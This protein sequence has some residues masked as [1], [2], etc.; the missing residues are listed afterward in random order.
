[1]C[2]LFGWQ[3]RPD[4]KFAK[5]PDYTEILAQA[6]TSYNDRRGGDSWGVYSPHLGLCKNWGKSEPFHDF[7]GHTPMLMGHTRKA[8]HGAIDMNNAHPFY[9]KGTWLA[10]NGVLSNHDELNTKYKRNHKVD[11]MHLLSHMV[12]GRPF[13]DIKGY[14]SIEWAKS[15]EK[16]RIYMARLNERGELA[17]V[18]LKDGGIFWTSSDTHAKDIVKDLGLKVKQTY[19]IKAEQIYFVED[20]SLYYIPKSSV[21]LSKEPTKYHDWRKGGDSRHEA[22]WVGDPNWDWGSPRPTP[23]TTN[24]ITSHA[25]PPAPKPTPVSRTPQPEQQGPKVIFIGRDGEEKKPE[26]KPASMIEQLKKA[27][28]DFC[29]PYVEYLLSKVPMND[30]H[31]FKIGWQNCMIEA[32]RRGFVSLAISAAKE[33]LYMY[34]AIKPVHIERMPESAALKLISQSV[35]SNVELPKG[36]S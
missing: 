20:G 36:A 25:N 18:Q 8:T 5:D 23:P 6:L 14:G 16:G 15:R 22:W 34:S 26:K 24:V 33:T 17:V 19:D 29:V 12:E 13:T 21:A 3:F 32:K 30:E 35:P 9:E 27:G 11:S 31:L 7:F 1:M 28:M 2:G 10:H 4:S